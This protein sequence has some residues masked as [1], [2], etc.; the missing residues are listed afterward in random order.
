MTDKTKT[1]KPFDHIIV[2]TSKLIRILECDDEI[3]GM[4]V[5][6]AQFVGDWCEDRWFVTLV[7]VKP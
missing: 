4:R 6:A 3:K 2:N 5:T 7:E 1:T